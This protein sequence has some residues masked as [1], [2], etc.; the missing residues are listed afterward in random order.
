MV[1]L[2]VGSGYRRELAWA[3]DPGVFCDTFQPGSACIIP[4]GT[5]FRSRWMGRGHV[6]VL[7]VDPLLLVDVQGARSKDVPRL[8]RMAEVD[9]PLL[10][11]L[12]LA[13]RE[14]LAREP[15][16][17]AVYGEHLGAAVALHLLGRYGTTEE[18]SPRGSLRQD[19]F[20]R[21][22]EHVE[23]HLES[24][25]SLRELAALAEVSPFH[26]A[27][28][29]K[30]RIRLSPHQFVLCRRVERAKVLLA[31]S[32]A[33]LSKIATQC[34]FS[35]QSHFTRAF[36][37]MSGMPPARWRATRARRNGEMAQPQPDPRQD[38]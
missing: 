16:R 23:Q 1:M 34:G 29:F 12:I 31:H 36:H 24:P 33:T 22:A 37:R 9:D 32:T 7:A 4:A 8:M 2:N 20:R 38:R 13:L 21:V 5:G 35:H 11:H 26:F 27:R 10:A 18:S 30:E 15:P 3:D 6:V 25:I 14:A 17:Q 28:T 19:W